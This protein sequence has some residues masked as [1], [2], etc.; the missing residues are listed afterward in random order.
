M[1]HLALGLHGPHRCPSTGNTG[2]L[3]SAL[4]SARWNGTTGAPSETPLLGRKEPAGCRKTT[5]AR[6]PSRDGQ[7][8][9]RGLSGDRARPRGLGSTGHLELPL[10]SV[11]V[12][13]ASRSRV[14]KMPKVVQSAWNHPARSIDLA[15][16]GSQ[17]RGD[18]RGKAHLEPL[19]S[20]GC[21][22]GVPSFAPRPQKMAGLFPTLSVDATM[23]I[24]RTDCPASPQ[25]SPEPAARGRTAS[26]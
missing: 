1:A 2:D 22:R 24:Y 18:L 7:A 13:D 16:L 23:Q 4:V 11:A 19:L 17:R 14:P 6:Q 10:D 26:T 21:K 3:S 12:G 25:P 15:T 8:Q 9:A 5:S 20:L